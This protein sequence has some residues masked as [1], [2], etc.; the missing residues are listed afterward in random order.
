[1]YQKLKRVILGISISRRI[2]LFFISLIFSSLLVTGFLFQKI[3]FSFLTH[4]IEES[5][6][7]TTIS[8][9]SYIK[10]T[11]S[12]INTYLRIIL[13]NPDV[14]SLLHS[15][16]SYSEISVRENV[17]ELIFLMTHNYQEISSIFII[18]RKNR[19]FF[20]ERGDVNSF[21]FNDYYY[22]DAWSKAR[23]LSGASYF[24][25]D[26]GSIFVHGQKT[27]FISNIRIINSLN[28]FKP[29]GAVAINVSEDILKQSFKDISDQYDVKVFILNENDK[30]ITSSHKLTNDVY[31]FLHLGND[32]G[33]KSLLDKDKEIIYSYHNIKKYDWK[34]VTVSSMEGDKRFYIF[35]LTALIALLTLSLLVFIGSMVI[36]KMIT[37]PVNILAGSMEE[38]G[39]GNLKKV[40][41]STSI[42]EFNYLRDGY[43]KLTDEVETLIHKVIKQEK[44]K[45]KAELNTLQAQIKPHFLYNTFDSIASLALMGDTDQVYNMV[46]SLGTFY[47]ISLSKGR[48]VISLGEELEVLKSYLKILSIRYDNF[49]VNFNLDD[50]FFDSPVLKLIL[51]PFVEN[52]IYHGIKPKGEKG[53]INITV[54]NE[55]VFL[56]LIIEDDGVGM[57]EKTLEKYI[58]GDKSF[59][60]KGTM[61]RIRLYYNRDDLV[62][63]RSKRGIGTTVKIKI[64]Q[65]VEVI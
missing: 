63:I 26:G 6:N 36:T 61:E 44:N 50:N 23:R 51:Q 45:R 29:I 18:D 48:E 41:F 19:K 20:T 2:L 13:S 43:N 5:A 65:E 56:S 35:L 8:I 30:L 47:R 28:T 21:E 1:M 57:D 59:G 58:S 55:E 42:Q 60:V 33:I 52:S 38:L 31:D 12:R 22:S 40:E 3:Y 64:P 54:L 24:A 14:Q 17:E 25:V 9:S 11:L 62:E 34:I 53:N 15:N 10:S 32:Q 39:R 16:D 37:K 4:Q 49:S 27:D 46:S 7:Q